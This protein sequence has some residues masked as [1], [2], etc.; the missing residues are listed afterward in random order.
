MI[1]RTTT[2]LEIIGNLQITAGKDLPKEKLEQA[3]Q[4]IQNY[5]NDVSLDD[6]ENL[7]TMDLRG[8]ALA[9]WVLMQKR[10][11]GQPLIHVYNPNFEQH[12]WQTTHTI[13]EIVTDDMPMLVNSISM[14]LKQRELAIH[15]IIHPIMQARRDENGQLLELASGSDTTRDFLA[16]SVMQFQIDRITNP[17]ALRELKQTIETIIANARCVFEDRPA[18][19]DKMHSIAAG[20][21]ER[22]PDDLQTSEAA[23]LLDWLPNH[24]FVFLGYTEFV[25]DKNAAD[26]SLQVMQDKA[27][28]LCRK[29]ASGRTYELDQLIPRKTPSYI[30]SEEVLSITKTNVRSPLHRADHLDLISLPRYDKDNTIVGKR[31][32]IGLFTSMVYNASGADIP[33]LRHRIQNVLQLS[34]HRHGSHAARAL[35]NILETFP[36]DTLFQTDEQTVL[37]IAHG[38]LQLQDRQHIKLFGLLDKY[39][40]FCDCLVYIPREIYHRDLRIKI[41]KILVE[42][43]NGDNVEFNIEFSSESALAR[44]HY[45][46]QFGE[47]H[48]GEPDW[49]EIEKAVVNAARS[50][51]DSFHDA[52]REY[53]GEERANTLFKQYQAGIP[54]N[55]KENFSPRAACIDIEHLENLTPEN[56]PGISFYRPLVSAESQVKSKLFSAGKYIAL[57]DVIPVIE[58]MGL[59]VDHERPYE[60][61]RKDGQTAWIHEFTAHHATG[62]QIDPDLSGEKFKQAFLKIWK[63]EIEDDGFNRLVLDAN[64]T[65]RQ[66]TILRSYCKYLLQIRVPF[67]QTYMIES[68]VRN[69]PITRNIVEYFEVRF[70]PAQDKKREARADKLLETMETQLQA[71]TSLDEDRILHAYINLIQATVRTNF[72]RCDAN[73]E[74][75]PYLSYKLKPGMI[76]AMPRPHPMFDIFVYSPRVDGVHLRGGKVARGGLRWSDRREDFRTEVLGLMKAQTVKNAVIVPVGSKGGF[77]VKNSPQGATRDE[78]MK[79]VVYCY[80]TF[81]RG[82]LDLTDNL[83]GRKT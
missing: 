80:Q 39:T 48:V 71:V 15:L 10:Q 44:I 70:D 67:S 6:L 21:R 68:L 69:A 16:E 8:A 34:R 53:F 7:Q 32:F 45:I 29:E 40:R 37:K 81:L 25:L 33:W 64:L 36:R 27:L 78:L 47:D 20:L 5:Y 38:I 49:R 26:I 76:S 56:S 73:G 65:W 14:E 12:G 43:L 63:G 11:P 18:M 28:G 50:W 17:T 42:Q 55:Y 1:D 41:Q 22:A 3:Q 57:S 66:A 72:Y 2:A 82:L 59:K 60:I 79:E 58:H 24:R 30:N 52:L 62:L 23:E 46:I 77:I 74:A 75:L 9:H 13:I 61:I 19:Q 51:D 31:C 35:Q 83:E 54:G 4:F